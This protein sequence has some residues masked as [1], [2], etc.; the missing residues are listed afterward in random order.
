[1]SLIRVLLAEDHVLVRE[2][3]AGLL[4][5][6]EDIEV[7]CEASTGQEAI[8]GV[9]AATPDVA[10]LDITM[11]KLNGM[12]AARRIK[13]RHPDT[14]VVF[15]TMHANEGYL[16]EALNLGASGFV[17]KR[18]A[19]E[20]LILA[21]RAAAQGHLFISPALASYAVPGR[22]SHSIGDAESGHLDS[23]TGRERE[24]LQLIA[25]GMT[26]GQIAEHLHLS[27]KTVQS[28]RA[29]VMGKLQAHCTADLV[30]YAIRVGL[31][32]PDL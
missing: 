9:Q 6:E 7:C 16:R 3:L 2:G 21:I 8:R 10:V 28:H 12:E 20:E 1:M 14:S 24:V 19:P 11:P 32:L 22:T 25:E 5:Q 4:Q 26:S 18:A 30:K 29:N 23:L 15:L 31:T 17:L 27:V 13:D